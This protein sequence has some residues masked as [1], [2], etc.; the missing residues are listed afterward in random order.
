MSGSKTTLH[1]VGLGCPR[2]DVDAEELAGRL[3]QAG[4]EVV[5][6][7]DQA[8]VVLVNTCGFIEAAKQDSIDQLLAAADL[9]RD[10]VAQAVIATGCL[11]ERYGR[12]LALALPEAD[13]VVGFDGYQ[14]IAGTIRSVLAGQP[15][16]SHQPQDRRRL[17]PV[18]PLDRPAQRRAATRPN[19]TAPG[20]DGGPPTPRRRLGQGPSAPLK[21]ASGC[22][23]RCAFCAI[24][25][26]RGA[27]S[28]RPSDE[29]VA[30]AGWLVGHGVRELYCV[31]EN[32]TSY[33]KDLGRRDALEDLLGQLA[34][35]DPGAWVRL[36][37][38][39]PAE[40]RPSLIDRVAALPQ[41]V[42][43]FDLPFQH[44]SR[45]LLRRMRRFGDGE[46]FL[47][48][49]DR[50]RQVAPAAGLRSN[51]IVGF[52]GETPA[53]VQELIDFLAAAELDAIGVFGYSEEEGTAAAELSG[54]LDQAEITARVEEVADLA[55]VV[56]AERAQ[57]RVGQTVEV[58][59]EAWQDGR[60]QG[61]CRHQG[62]EADGETWLRAAAGALRP[63]QLVLGQVVRADGVD[64]LVEPAAA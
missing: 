4:F 59:V 9:K 15:H 54:R 42:D 12:E 33:G 22:D 36:S 40:L 44:A 34:Q 3:E 39:Q 25:S 16:L 57:D 49:I 50:I 8:Q 27:Y 1:L 45:A 6:R 32:T 19:S 51:F 7:P 61:R 20:P 46:S 38:L 2:N 26:F 24:P 60:W 17:L 58:M 62:P 5:D 28:S 14:S 29:I 43:Y 55:E 53:Q 10:G 30:E 35:V 18:T 64:L 52:P 48:L 47:G 21:I 31:S 13:A 56:M 63:G 11:A 41:V 37:Y 23:R